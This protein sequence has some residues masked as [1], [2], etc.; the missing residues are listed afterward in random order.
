MELEVVKDQAQDVTVALFDT[1]GNYITG[2]TPSDVDPIYIRKEGGSL[3]S[4]SISS[5]NFTEID[6]TNAP[7]LYEFT[8]SASDLDTLG[9]FI[10]VVPANGAISLEQAVTRMDVVKAEPDVNLQPVQNTL[11]T[12][13][14]DVDTVLERVLGLVQ[15]NM[16]ITNH[17]YDS[18]NNLIGS[19]IHIYPTKSDAENQTNPIAEYEMTAS[20]DAQNRLTDYRMVKL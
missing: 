19:T 11:S 3:Q 8:F 17:N 18:N 14:D 7:G 13:F 20:Y 6:A 4:K 16:R 9:E 1:D 5:S 12:R 10:A 2:V 15:E